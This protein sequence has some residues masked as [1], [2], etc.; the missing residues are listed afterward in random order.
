MRQAAVQQIN[1]LAVAIIVLG[2]FVLALPIAAMITA[3]REPQLL[4]QFPPG[5]LAP[6]LV[7][8]M[9]TGLVY[10]YAG[11]QLQRVNPDVPATIRAAAQATILF[12]GAAVAE[13]ASNLFVSG[14]ISIFDL[15]YVIVIAMLTNSLLVLSGRRSLGE[16][17]RAVKLRKLTS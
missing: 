2:G 13:V 14:K 15:A 3:L 10:Y 6:L 5:T 4:N 11:R 1:N 12:A 7:S 9:L 16:L 8:T 17:A